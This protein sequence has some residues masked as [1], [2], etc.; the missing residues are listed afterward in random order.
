MSI[1]EEAIELWGKE[2]QLGMALE[3]LLEL[4]TAI[5]KYH[6]EP[7]SII[8]KL[9]VEEEIGDVEIMLCQLRYI[10]DEKEIDRAKKSKLKR[11]RILIDIEKR[12]RN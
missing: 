11:L 6:R 4:A 8:R 2:T 10:F 1:Y 12:K 3:E 9:N 7:L 5:M